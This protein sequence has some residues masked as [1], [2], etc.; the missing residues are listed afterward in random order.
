MSTPVLLLSRAEPLSPV[1]VVASGDAARRLALRLLALPADR[2]ERLRGVSAAGLIALV[3]DEADLPWVDG[4]RYLGR[5]PLAPTLLLPTALAVGAHPA[6][7]ERTV[8]T[9]A[10][11]AAPPLAVLPDPLRVIPLGGARPVDPAR[12]RAWLESPR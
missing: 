10:P 5:D 12:L 1:A 11:D 8:L 9:V 7:L 4:A 6:L 3:G 2:L